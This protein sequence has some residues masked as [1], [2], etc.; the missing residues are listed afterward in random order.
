M[1]NSLDSASVSTPPPPRPGPNLSEVFRSSTSHLLPAGTP[2]PCP[3]RGCYRFLRLLRRE[4]G[5]G[6]GR[7]RL[8]YKGPGRCWRVQLAHHECP[9]PSR[10][11]S[12][13]LLDPTPPA[14]R[15]RGRFA[16]VDTGAALVTVPSGVHVE[17]LPRPSASGGHHPQPPGAR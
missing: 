7:R 1:R 13:N 16:S 9:L 8:R 11:S 3:S 5:R 10:S 2:L 12:P 4:E 15:D 17:P 6:A 14:R